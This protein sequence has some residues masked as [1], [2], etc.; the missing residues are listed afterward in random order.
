[1]WIPKGEEWEAL[2]DWA[3]HIYTTMHKADINK[4]LLCSTLL[5][6]L[7]LPKLEGNPKKEGTDSLCYTVK[8]NITLQSNYTLIKTN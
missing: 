7:W 6:A 8:T 1:M 2:V 4:N 3:W 5:S